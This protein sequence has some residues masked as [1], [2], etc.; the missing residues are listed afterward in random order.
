MGRIDPAQILGGDLRRRIRNQ[1]Q[2][3]VATGEIVFAEHD[4]RSGL[5]ADNLCRQGSAHLYQPS[6]P[7]HVFGVLHMGLARQI[8]WK[9]RQVAGISQRRPGLF[10]IEETSMRSFSR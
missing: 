10:A 5:K 6:W 8:G 2:R 9:G 3:G 7:H 1:H 4:L